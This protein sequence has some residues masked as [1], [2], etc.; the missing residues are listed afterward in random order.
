[1]S[2]TL[3][4]ILAGSLIA[5]SSLVATAA[6]HPPEEHEE[7]GPVQRLS[8]I[9]IE[10]PQARPYE[11]EPY[12]ADMLLELSDNASQSVEAS[13]S[14]AMS[15][16]YTSCYV[17]TPYPSCSNKR[18]AHDELRN[19]GADVQLDPTSLITGNLHF[20]YKYTRSGLTVGNSPSIVG[21]INAALVIG[22]HWYYANSI[23]LGPKGGEF[24]ESL[25][26]HWQA[27]C[28]Y[29]ENHTEQCQDEH[30]DA[31]ENAGAELWSHDAALV[32]TIQGPYGYSLT[33]LTTSE[34]LDIKLDTAGGSYVDLPILPPPAPI[35][36]EVDVVIGHEEP[37]EP[38]PVVEAREGEDG[39]VYYVPGAGLPLLGLA[40]V[41]AAFLVRRRF[42]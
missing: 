16:S 27:S 29:D 42:G 4:W 18:Y 6:G 30:D 24:N 25:A 33:S 15:Y 31:P 32:L 17:P 26:F 7:A 10:A 20:S 28:S 41:G 22:D 34:R 40:S 2:R 13:R 12:Y 3:L 21:W 8:I 11:Q 37:V 1:M 19:L 5:S 9:A 23:P 36:E 35:V 14:Y 39:T 38:V